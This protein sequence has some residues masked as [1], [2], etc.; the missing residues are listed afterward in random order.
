MPG[1]DKGG[2]SID[3]KEDQLTIKGKVLLPEEQEIFLHKEY[4]VG[5]YFR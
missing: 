5:N 4:A 3:L 1:V 2:V